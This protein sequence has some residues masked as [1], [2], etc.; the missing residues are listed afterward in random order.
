VSLTILDVLRA[1][2][3]LTPDEP[4]ILGCTGAI[5][6]Y[7][8]LHQ[9]VEATVRQLWSA[10]IERNDRVAVI[11]PGGPEMAVAFLAVASAAACAPLNPAYRA[12]E[13]EFYLSDLGARALVLPEN[14]DSPARAI[15]E[16]LRIRVLEHVPL[17]R[18]TGLFVLEPVASPVSV[19]Q[20]AEIDDVALIL[21]TSGTTSRPKI[22]PLTQ[23][24]LT[25]SAENIRNTLLLTSA[26]RCL[27]VMP[28]FH[29]HGLIAGV[30]A[31]M[32]A[33]GSIV[34]TPG[35]DVSKVFDWIQEYRPTWYTAVPA[36][37][38]AVLA[39]AP[40]KENAIARSALRFIRSSSSALPARVMLEMEQVFQVP[41]IE[42]YGMTEASHQMASNPL[43]PGR[44]KPGSVGRPAGPEIAVM[45]ENG[46]T[47]PEGRIGEIVIR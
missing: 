43:P 3:Q 7:F 18:T 16:K 28:L 33:G 41:V 31:P 24:N 36:M 27:N 32:T 20:F 35:F 8:N 21:H 12:E 5:L 34:C 38:Q 2:A 45:D 25:A 19:G 30:L 40:A 14:M 9:R 13:F 22:V 26:D 44:R 46:R 4:A 6:S 1:N 10:G 42:S 47:L 11:L 15:A 23:R 17:D 37:H 39:R 29:I